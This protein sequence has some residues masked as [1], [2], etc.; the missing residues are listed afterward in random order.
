MGTV[1][2]KI[3]EF[4]SKTIRMVGRGCELVAFGTLEYLTSP[5]AG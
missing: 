5:Q 2:A 1:E 3:A 4:E